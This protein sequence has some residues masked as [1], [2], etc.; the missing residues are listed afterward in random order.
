MTLGAVRFKPSCGFSG[1]G[2]F[3]ADCDE[4]RA[5]IVAGARDAAFHGADVEVKRGPNLFVGVILDVAQR[6]D[7]AVAG[8]ESRH[9]RFDEFGKFYTRV[10]LRGIGRVVGDE[11]REGRIIS[12]PK[13]AIQRERRVSAATK[14]IPVAIARE[15]DG[16]AV[17]PRRERGIAAE[18]REAAV[19]ANKRILSDFFGVGAVAQQ[20]KGGG[21][22]FHPMALHDFNEGG[23][24]ADLEALDEDR[25]VFRWCVGDGGGVLGCRRGLVLG[26]GRGW[27]F[28]VVHA[29]AVTLARARWI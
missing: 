4:L 7:F 11:F 9:A 2:K 12:L 28:G 22:N 27:G 29:V 16:D 8:I 18:T 23:F 5:E 17:Q 6:E 3:G 15:V 1:G 19:R 21:E 10:F 25:V 24:V 26:L 13:I 14:K 20:T